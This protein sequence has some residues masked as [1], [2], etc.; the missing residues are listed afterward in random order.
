MKKQNLFR[1]MALSVAVVLLACL[2]S[3][4]DTPKYA[5][6]IAKDA[7]LVASI[8][9][10][11]MAEKAQGDNGQKVNEAL[12]KQLEQQGFSAELQSKAKEIVNDPAEAGIDLRKP[13]LVFVDDMQKE[14]GGMVAALHDADKFAELCNAMAKQ[15]GLDPVKQEDD[16]RTLAIDDQVAVA[17]NDDMMLVYANNKHGDVM[18]EAKRRLLAE[19]GESVLERDDFKQMCKATSDAQLLVSGQVIED[20]SVDAEKFKEALPADMKPEDFSVLVELNSEKGQLVLSA[21]L[22]CLT[23][24]AQKA[25]EKYGDALGSIQGD[26]MDYVPASSLFV[27]SANLKGDGLKELLLPVMKKQGSLSSEQEK[28]AGQV[29]ESLKGD[30]VLSV[31]SFDLSQGPEVFL[32]AKV[33]DEKQMK[34]AVAKLGGAAL[35]EV[36][37]GQYSMGGNT[38]LGVKNGL[39]YASSKQPVLS[40]TKPKEAADAS[41]FKGN[42]VCGELNVKGVM[43]NPLLQGMMQANSSVRTAAPLLKEIDK[44]DYVLVDRDKVELRL[45][46]ANADQN[47]LQLLVESACSSL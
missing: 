42:L 2:A 25:V 20:G 4:S 45:L 16:V 1:Q 31:N 5:R 41:R 3:C 39:F 43:A 47:P 17:F 11:Q 21:Q 35:E 9:V 13:V 12:L 40:M 19:E 29:M 8:N 34:E 36:E 6:V 30:A 7:H 33:D 23:D 18:A 26:L 27:L 38:Y 28:L 37:P 44:L 14:T 46:L 10:K 22:I 15:G 24:V 32:I